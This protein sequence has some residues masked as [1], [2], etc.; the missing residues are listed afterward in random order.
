MSNVRPRAIFSMAATQQHSH[1]IG[2]GCL[3][4]CLL[5]ACFVKDTPDGPPQVVNE[6]HVQRMNRLTIHDTGSSQSVV[7]E[8]TYR[9][10]LF[11][12]RISFFKDTDWTSLDNVTQL[13]SSPPS[14]LIEVGSSAALLTVSRGEP[15]VA[16][17]WR[18]E[19][20]AYMRQLSSATWHI[21]DYAPAHAGTN[22]CSGGRLFD[23]KTLAQRRIH[24]QPSG[25]RNTLVGVSPDQEVF[26]WY[27]EDSKDPAGFPAGL[28]LVSDSTGNVVGSFAL[29][30]ESISKLPLTMVRL[31]WQP[32]FD[33]EF[34]WR[35]N[36]EGQWRVQR[37][38]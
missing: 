9:G 24:R 27:N 7:Y 23:G 32:W 34:S 36:A 28:L 11:P 5:S 37:K 26:A 33:S 8:I 2:L 35:K 31:S 20:Y 29:S 17:L 21:P 13:P 16:M 22:E 19:T 25:C 6:F 1:L 30:G 18:D 3:F 4:L 14:L 15:E 38:V 10:N 12:K